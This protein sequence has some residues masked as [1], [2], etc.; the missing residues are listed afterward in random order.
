LLIQTSQNNSPKTILPKQFSQN[1]SPKTI[2]PKQTFNPPGPGGS[3]IFNPNLN[4]ENHKY[5]K[6][7]GHVLS[8]NPSKELKGGKMPK[9]DEKRRKSGSPESA[10]R[11]E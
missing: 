2:L 3:L 7:V 6:I 11:E 10:G 4:P 1:N 5:E 9:K 8:R